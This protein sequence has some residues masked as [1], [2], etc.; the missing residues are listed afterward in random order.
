MLAART[1]MTD[2]DWG[3]VMG[4]KEVL[5][6]VS[7]LD[8]V[9]QPSVELSWESGQLSWELAARWVATAALAMRWAE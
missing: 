9:V 7:K 8:A 6:W 5:E 1:T 2:R 4:M 3:C